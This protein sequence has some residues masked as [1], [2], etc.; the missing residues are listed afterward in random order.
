MFAG[1]TVH[2]LPGRGM[3]RVR[4]NVLRGIVRDHGGVV[5]EELTSSVSHVVA[6]TAPSAAMPVEAKLVTA[7]WLSQSVL[8]GQRLEE[9][10]FE[11]C[12]PAPAKA[13]DPMS[14]KRAAAP[15]SQALIPR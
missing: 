15:A 9:A 7:D 5:A 10:K 12:S 11:V 14:P 8:K 4:Q 6:A 3:T 13:S 2:L 1:C